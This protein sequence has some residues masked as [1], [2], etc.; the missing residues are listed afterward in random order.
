MLLSHE[1]QG[2]QNAGALG[3]GKAS[4]LYPT[5]PIRALSGLAGDL[6]PSSILRFLTLKLDP[7]LALTQGLGLIPSHLFACRKRRLNGL[8]L[9]MRPGKPKPHVRAGVVR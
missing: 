2:S 3:R 1:I 8:V 7:P 5:P 6:N 9:R 4:P